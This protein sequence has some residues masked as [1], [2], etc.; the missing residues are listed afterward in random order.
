MMA[1]LGELSSL[2]IPYPLL[3]GAY[4]WKIGKAVFEKG[5]VLLVAISRIVWA[6]T[7]NLY[8]KLMLHTKQ[9]FYQAK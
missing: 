6:V 2:C 1:G 5:R 8:K 4:F 7:C 9:I 3:I